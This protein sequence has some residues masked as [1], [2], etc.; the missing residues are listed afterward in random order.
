MNG[1]PVTPL[2][3]NQ[4]QINLKIGTDLLSALD[5]HINKHGGD[6]SRFIR[7]AIIEALAGKGIPLSLDLAAAPSRIGKGGKPTHTGYAFN[8]TA[9]ANVPKTETAADKVNYLRK[10]KSK[11]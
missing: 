6:R 3:S 9:A 11:H 5:D 10:K 7:E 2:S 1:L 4:T 8:E